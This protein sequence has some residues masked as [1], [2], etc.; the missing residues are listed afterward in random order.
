MGTK[1]PAAAGS[2][3][4]AGD[5]TDIQ[6]WRLQKEAWRQDRALQGN[7]TVDVERSTESGGDS[8]AGI[9][10][11]Y[12]PV[13]GL[14]DLD[15]Y[16]DDDL[17]RYERKWGGIVEDAN[18]V[19]IFYDVTNSVTQQDLIKY[20]GDRYEIMNSDFDEQSG[21]IEVLAKLARSD[22]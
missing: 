18:H 12:T 21:R 6:T 16:I 5:S 15:A 14:T 8:S 4:Y 1:L 3:N 17:K 22:V 20:N 7:L 11:D 13:A 10:P 2:G 9:Q 19:F